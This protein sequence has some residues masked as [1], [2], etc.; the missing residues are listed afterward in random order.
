MPIGTVDRGEVSE[1]E[2]EWVALIVPSSFVVQDPA[3]ERVADT[4][5]DEEP[6]MIIA[7]IGA[8]CI[9]VSRARGK[10]KGGNG[11]AFRCAITPKV[12][13]SFLGSTVYNLP[14]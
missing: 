1:F 9:V 3:E 11:E 13:F 10:T 14:P 7:R 2:G 4:D 8:F 5:S 12:Y 6:Q